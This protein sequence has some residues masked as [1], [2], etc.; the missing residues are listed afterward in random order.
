MIL[1]QVFHSAADVLTGRWR[2]TNRAYIMSG[3]V[4]ALKTGFA[5]LDRAIGTGGLPQGHLT[6]L[7]GPDTGGSVSVMAKIAA[8]FQRKQLPVLILDL[9]QQLADDH[10]IK[11]G[12]I[13]PELLC[14]TPSDIFAMI[15]S[16][17]KASRQPGL[18]VLYFGFVP[19][20]LGA[21][22]GATLKML[23]SRL[24]RLVNRSEAVFL[25]V[26]HTEDVNPL[27]YTN[28]LPT[29]P[30]NEVA[31]V[32]LWVQDEG[33]IKKGA[34]IGGYRGA[35][36]VIKNKLAPSGKGANIRI[37]FVDPILARLED[38]LGF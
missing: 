30:L 25:A 23:L 18:V 13:A 8:K 1:K 33:W 36:T 24:R 7:I 20:T 14:Q 16:L 34:D 31:D 2:A 17:E 27:I 22:P 4:S 35:I 12:L 26:T 32:R 19:H 37:P 28:Y 21:I 3:N 5:Q 29:F 11:C 10:L 38:E 6:E 15:T 9:A